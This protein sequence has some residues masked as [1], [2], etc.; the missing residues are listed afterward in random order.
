ML[1]I[2]EYAAKLLQKKPMEIKVGD[3]VTIKPQWRYPKKFEIISGDIVQIKEQL[4]NFLPIRFT[5]D[6]LNYCGGVYIAERIMNDGSIYLSRFEFV[7]HD[8]NHYDFTVTGT[9][10]RLLG[11]I[12][13]NGV[14][15]YAWEK[16]WLKPVNK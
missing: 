13:G 12:G 11:P 10:V 15:R 1:N 7:P 6:M 14:S 16:E 5:R 9:R 4:W 2:K 8:D 3:L